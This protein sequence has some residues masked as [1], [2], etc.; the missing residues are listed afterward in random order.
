MDEERPCFHLLEHL[1]DFV[2]G[3]AAQTI[4]A[5]IEQHL[6]GCE[7]CRIVI[8]T[9][10]QTIHLYH[11]LPTATLPEPARERLY[12]TLELAPYLVNRREE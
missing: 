6:A 12:K 7:N 11:T 3:A 10:R 8:D 4:C 9:L 2:D 1:S 5:E